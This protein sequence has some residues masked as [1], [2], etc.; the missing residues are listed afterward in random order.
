MSNI[1]LNDGRHAGCRIRHK[2]IKTDFLQHYGVPGQ[3]WGV[4][5]KEYEPV[6][7]DRRKLKKPTPSMNTFNKT[8]RPAPSKNQVL[9][10]VGKNETDK[11][12]GWVSQKM[13]DRNRKLRTASYVGAAAIGLLLAY[14]AYRYSHVMKAK[15]YSGLLEKFIS[16][17]PSANLKT[18]SGKRLLQKGIHYAEV[19]SRKFTDA[20][21]TN[22]YLKKRGLLMKTKDA[23]RIYK[24][25]N[26]IKKCSVYTGGGSK[27]KQAVYR[28]R[29]ARLT[30][31]LL[32][33]YIV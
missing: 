7:V 23:T 14:G 1:Y 18:E 28:A 6:S 2:I 20:K 4:I 22:L 31:R 26:L 11:K 16:Q 12:G 21:A 29:K 15:A 10:P 30:K 33:N 9:K 25:K 8:F 27:F 3:K 32:R 5:T 19:N 24:A 17:N 13:A